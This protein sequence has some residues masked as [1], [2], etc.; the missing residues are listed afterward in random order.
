VAGV[1]FYGENIMPKP[2]YV[3]YRNEE[4]VKMRDRENMTCKEIGLFFNI[5]TERARQLVK[6][7]GCNHRIREKTILKYRH[8]FIHNE[9]YNFTIKKENGCWEYTR[10]K[11]GCGY[12]ALRYKGKRYYA[13]RYSYEITNGEIPAG[14]HVCH[15]CDN[16]ICVNPDH[17]FLGTVADNM[18]DRDVKGRGNKGKPRKISRSK[19][20]RYVHKN[21]NS[22][23]FMV[24]IKGKYYGSF[25][26]TLEASKIAKIKSREVYGKN[27]I[28]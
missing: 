23:L 1:F 9:F 15:K 7:L 19:Y 26:S 8:S 2:E 21:S 3:K 17:L 14:L 11:C 6:E 4:I 5:S 28:L 25:T 18:H 27:S 16:P 10:S 20:G 24:V 13:H 12:G 22:K